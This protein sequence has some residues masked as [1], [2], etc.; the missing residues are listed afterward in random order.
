MGAGRTKWTRLGS[1][2]SWVIVVVLAAGVAGL[3]GLRATADEEHPIPDQVTWAGEVGPIIARACLD[4]HGENPS[5]PFSLLSYEDAAERAG[6]IARVTSTR[7]MPPWLPRA[8]H[9]TFAGERLLSERDVDLFRVWAEQGA[10]FGSEAS[11]LLSAD[12]DD[13]E[14]GDEQRPHHRE[15]ELEEVGGHHAPQ[16]GQSGVHEHE[17]RQGHHDPQTLIPGK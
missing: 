5:A 17:Y 2:A 14:P 9:G 3:S 10:R 11:G 6:R 7:R 8:E 15:R 1:G 13:G 12:V 16:T 4:C